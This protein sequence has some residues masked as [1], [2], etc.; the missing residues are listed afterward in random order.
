MSLWPHSQIRRHWQCLKWVSDLGLTTAADA[1]GRPA[2]A[3]V[4]SELVH[5]VMHLRCSLVF[6]YI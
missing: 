5:L 6:L 2:K 1:G 3:E 4:R